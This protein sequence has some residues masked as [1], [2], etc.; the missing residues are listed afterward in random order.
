MS[1]VSHEGVPHDV[2]RK[3]CQQLN[4]L[5]EGRIENRYNAL[6]AA[7][8]TG[9][10][11]QGDFVAHE[12]P[13]EAGSGAWTYIILGWVCTVSGTP[14][15]FEEVRVSTSTHN[16]IVGLTGTLAEFNAAL[17][18]ADFASGGGVITGTSSG[19]NTGDQTSIVGITG[20]LAEFNAALTG[21]DFAT[22]GGTA[23]G[24]NTGDQTNISGN[25]ATVTTNANLTGPITS[26]G[27]A[28][29]V[30][31]Q[32]GTGSTFVMNT[33]PVLVTPTLGVATGQSVTITQTSDAGVLV[34][35]FKHSGATATN[36]FCSRFW[37]TGDPNDTLRYFWTAVSGAGGATAKGKFASN[38]GLYSVQANHV[39]LSDMA[40][41]PVFE[42]YDDA[43]LADIEAKFTQIRRGR[44]KYEGQT[45]NDWNYGV[46]AQ[47]VKEKI[48]E[49][50]AVWNETKQVEVAVV[51]SKTGEQKTETRVIETPQ[52]ERLLGVHSH[53]MAQ[54][55]Q[56]LLVRLIGRVAVLEAKLSAMNTK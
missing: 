47:S 7:P 2:L 6:A 4:G 20:S 50:S 42:D 29:A 32:T 23:T 55:G 38:G 25:A 44:F 41:K 36:Q 33:S 49:L 35:D 11:M 53:D 45:H 39:D 51:D 13:A 52:A 9:S 22:G 21:A 54:I 17:T 28:T 56:A 46:S 14:G 5:S 34:A 30:A 37:L 48:P 19:T 1:K 24:S 10:Y 16:S 40:V 26:T 43:M 27:N 12:A 15:T 3:I 8:T 18:G 31:S